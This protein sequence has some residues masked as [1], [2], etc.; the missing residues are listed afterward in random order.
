VERKIV[1]LKILQSKIFKK[2]TS[3]SIRFF[4]GGKAA[5]PTLDF[6]TRKG[7]S[8]NFYGSLTILA[9]AINL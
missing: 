8:S 3:C 7:I 2:T 6:I 5:V 9:G 4:L 1:F